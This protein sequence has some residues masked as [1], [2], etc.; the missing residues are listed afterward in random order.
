MTMRWLLHNFLYLYGRYLHPV[1]PK[2]VYSLH[3][4]QFDTLLFKRFHGVICIVWWSFHDIYKVLC[5]AGHTARRAF[6]NVPTHS[7]QV[8]LRS[9]FKDGSLFT[10]KWLKCLLKKIHWL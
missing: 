7:V 2:N 6:Q 4:V 3:Y 1:D 10:L 9:M 8:L 5:S